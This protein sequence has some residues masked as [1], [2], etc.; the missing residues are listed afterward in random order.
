MV[1]TSGFSSITLRMYQISAI[2][3]HSEFRYH[4]FSSI[5]SL[6][7]VSFLFI[8]FLCITG[9]WLRREHLKIYRYE[10]ILVFC[11]KIW[12]KFHSLHGCFIRT[13]AKNS[14]R[15]L[16]FCVFAFCFEFPLQLLFISEP[17]TKFRNV[18]CMYVLSG[19]ILSCGTRA[20]FTWLQF[21]TSLC[22]SVSVSLQ[23]HLV[24]VYAF[25]R[26]HYCAV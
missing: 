14:R 7:V 9:S 26:I 17:V 24:F 15:Q 8:Y 23:K 3:T 4:R 5:F 22:E 2:L 11:L 21:S 18:S 25:K 12:E 13:S 19:N 20:I 16:L 1:I 10:V 6:R